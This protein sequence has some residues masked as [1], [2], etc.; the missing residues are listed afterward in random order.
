[1]NGSGGGTKLLKK[2]WKKW[3]YIFVRKLV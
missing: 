3:K 2:Q 1:M